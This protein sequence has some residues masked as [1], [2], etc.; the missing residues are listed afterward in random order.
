MKACARCVCAADKATNPDVNPDRT[1]IF[2]QGLV[3]STKKKACDSTPPTVCATSALTTEPPTAA[4]NPIFKTPGSPCGE[5][6]SVPA[7]DLDVQGVSLDQATQEPPASKPAGERLVPVPQRRLKPGYTSYYN[8]FQRDQDMR[9]MARIGAASLRAGRPS[10]FAYLPLLPGG[11]TG[12]LMVGLMT[13]DVC[14][15]K[16]QL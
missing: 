9:I 13:W 14:Q 16:Y 10:L 1:D 3:A 6:S 4:D 11:F 15:S 7:G 12:V 8:K 5:L 2:V